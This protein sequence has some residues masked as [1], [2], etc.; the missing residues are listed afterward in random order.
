MNT[1]E[2]TKITWMQILFFA[3]PIAATSM[4]EQ[5]FNSADVMVVGRFV[6]SSAIAAVGSTTVLINLCI[7][8]YSGLSMGANV[9]IAQKIGA[10]DLVGI[11]KAVHS[12]LLFAVI[13]GLV[14]FLLGVSFAQ[15]ILR[16]LDTPQE[17]LADATQYLQ[18]YMISCLFLMVYNFA[19]AIMRANGDTKKPLY[20]LLFSGLLNVLFNLFFVAV[21]GLGVTGVAIATV[22]A[23]AIAASLLVY[24]LIKD[25]GVVKLRLSKLRLDVGM[26]CEILR[27]GVPAAIQGMMFNVANILIQ[28]A[29]NDLGPKAI[30]ASTI[31]LT[32]EIFVFYLMGSFSA[33]ALTF[34]GRGFGAGDFKSCRRATAIAIVLGEV[35]TMSLVALFLSFARDFASLYTSDSVIIA[36]VLTRMFWVLSFEMFSVVMEVLSGAMRGLGHSLLPA[37]LSAIFA[38]MVRI[39]WVLVVFPLV[40]N[41]RDLILV[42]PLTWILTT[43]AITIAYISLQKKLNKTATQA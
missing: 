34:N 38:C 18:I 23:N 7:N 1:L 21:C 36:L 26:L 16:L 42:F 40:H 35:L 32:A 14:M 15:D 12:S 17:I 8:I 3:L 9:M 2:K 39:I 11:S 41:F 24:F 37:S 31:A 30:A 20:C 10:R 33:A 5:L 43:I 13:S 27:I 19:A 4:L 22:I 6:G 28:T 29:I 25:K